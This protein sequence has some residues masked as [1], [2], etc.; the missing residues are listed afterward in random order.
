VD[1]AQT[2]AALN[3]LARN[4]WW[5]WNQDARSIFG[6][7]SPR[8]WSNVYHNPVAILH[9]VSYAELRARLMEPA[10]AARVAH[11]L[12]EFDAYLNTA[13]T[14]VLREVQDLK[15]RPIAYFS[16][17][18]GLHETL[19]IAAGGLGVLAGDHI[20]SASDLGL[21]FSGITLFYREGYFQQSINQD[22]WQTEYYNQLNPENLPMDAVTD[23][24]GTPLK[25]TVDIATD[26]VHF[27]AWR[28][29]VGRCPLYLLD[30]NLP[31]NPPHYRDL[32]LRVYGGDSTTRIQQEIL[33][34]I[35]GVKLLR[36]LGQ[37]PSVFHMNEGHAAFLALELIR[38]KMAYGAD[39]DA[40][41]EAT[42]EQCIFTTHTPVP[43][44]HDRFSPELMSYSLSRYEKHLELSH[45][46]LMAL[47][48]IDADNHDESF[49]MTVLALNTSR[50]ANGVSELHGEVSRD[51]WREKY[52]AAAGD[53]PIGHVTN[54]VH[55]LGWMSR[56]AR[57]FWQPRGLDDRPFFE[58]AN[59]PK[60][61][62]RVQ[63]PAFISD[64]ELWSLRCKL[65]RELVDFARERLIDHPTQRE[66]SFI[67]LDHLLDADTLTIG[68][69]RRFATYKRAPLIFDQLQQVVTLAKDNNRPVQFIFAGKAHPADDEGKRFIQ[70]I[71]HLSKHSDLR[72]HLVFLENYDIQVGR[73][74]ISG[75]DVWLNN[76]RRPLEASG[77]S[78][79]KTAAHGGLNCSIMDGWWRESFDGNNGFAIGG[80][81]HPEDTEEQ[82]RTDSENVFRVLAEE[83][84]PLFYERDE[85]GLPR[86]WIS[87][88]RGAMSSITPQYNTWR[89]VQE[90]ASKYYRAS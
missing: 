31:E 34:G 12:K 74:M 36:A 4:I 70:K 8:T 7:L 69:A 79:M 41:L 78:G 85:S 59:S 53:V 71:V 56:S 5:T 26:T 90:Y 87:R 45:E 47:G 39:F 23:A 50:A 49:C 54:G 2:I 30:T 33:L 58:T 18:F 9:E 6:E 51:M 37:E 43:A 61:W 13:D 1:A 27:R 22:N 28:I 55:L 24:D 15:D 67:Q 81:E 29:N 77:T 60:F 65:R 35:G 10:Y 42:R 72:G 86:A 3:C 68:F 83:V 21:P 11:V 25:C 63:D 46:R 89:M 88:M 19:P 75:C 84:I 44:G 57:R 73:R 16:A 80:D 76:P 40:A 20:K 52:G 62:E 64:E 32:T 17:E 82:D 14:W 38:E 66:G 48:R